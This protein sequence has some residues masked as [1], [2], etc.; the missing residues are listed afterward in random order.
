LNYHHSDAA[1][2]KR[3]CFNDHFCATGENAVDS[4]IA[5]SN[6][7]CC[8]AA[9]VA[10]YSRPPKWLGETSRRDFIGHGLFSRAAAAVYLSSSGRVIR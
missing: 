9:I 7:V 10:E 4:R 2:G 8:T 6:R 3:G 1:R 5:Q